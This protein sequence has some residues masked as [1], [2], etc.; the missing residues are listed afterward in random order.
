MIRHF[1]LLMV[2]GALLIC[3]SADAK[4][5]ASRFLQPGELDA[6][7][8]LPPP[9]AADSPQ[10][11][12]ELA[13]LHTLEGSRSPARLAQAQH[14]AEVENV[15]AIAE[16]LGPA[17]NLDQRPA[18]AKLF[19]DLRAEDELAAS[20]AKAYFHRL[21]P[22]AADAALGAS[23][24]L[25]QCDKGAPNSSYPSGHATMGFAAGAVLAQLMPGQAQAVL[26]RASDYA[27]S[28][29]VCGVHYRSDI[30]AGHVLA[31]ALV[32]K[33]MTK[34]AFTAELEAARAELAA[35]H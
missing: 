3:G 4:T 26:A 33:L 7:L 23:P 16:V 13:E 12:S 35:A 1:T 32:A 21:R 24:A 11:R 18:T 14:D 10:A 22:W 6:S 9:P 19:A 17:L 25:A 5:A 20:A 15:T 34:P 2:C 29:V 28:R 30:E 31:T 27:Y 8:V